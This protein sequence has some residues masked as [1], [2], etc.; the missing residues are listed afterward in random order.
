VAAKKRKHGKKEGI[1]VHER[2]AE[3]D[4]GLAAWRRTSVRV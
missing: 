3:T 1:L 4:G 2:R